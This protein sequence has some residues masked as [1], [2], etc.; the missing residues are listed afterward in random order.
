MSVSTLHTSSAYLNLGL[1]LL[2]IT[3]SAL[4]NT[5]SIRLLLA[6]ERI[7]GLPDHL[8]G[9]NAMNANAV[10]VGDSTDVTKLYLNILPG[11]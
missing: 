7:A 10:L 2:H 5:L 6:L 9:R 11:L 8:H 1:L 3:L 4:D